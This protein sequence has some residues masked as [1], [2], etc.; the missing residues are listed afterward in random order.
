MT[1]KNPRIVRMTAAHKEAV[2]LVKNG[3]DVRAYTLAKLLREVEATK[4]EC[5]S[6]GPV[7]MGP[8]DSA[9]QLPYFGAIATKAGL[10]W[11]ATVL[12]L[13][14]PALASAGDL[15]LPASVWVGVNS[16]DA[17]S[18]NRALARVPGAYESNPLLQGQGQRLAVKAATTSAVILLAHAVGRQH[19]KAARVFLYSASV[20][21]GAVA[22]H[23][24]QIGA[25]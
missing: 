11:A 1:K 13:I 10:K 21:V 12:L 20:V 24:S 7:Q 16:A 25:R 17:I 14:L 2:R 6:I 19:P 18:T 3:A 23:N 15:K 22:I 8:Y 4:P 9:G 5:I